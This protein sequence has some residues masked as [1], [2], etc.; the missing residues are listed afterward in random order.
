MPCTEVEGQPYESTQVY[1]QPVQHPQAVPNTV[2]YSQANPDL[3]GPA[4]GRAIEPIKLTKFNGK[5][6][7]EEFIADYL[8]IVHYNGWSD[9]QSLLQL[10]LALTG[11]AAVCK[12]SHSVELI[13]NDLRERYG[14]TIASS[15]RKYAALQ[16]GQLTLR[17]LGDEV[18]RLFHL[19][20]KT[21]SLGEAER[22]KI[23]KF[24][25]ALNNPEIHRFVLLS[26]PTSLVEAVRCAQAYTHLRR[27]EAR[28]V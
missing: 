21:S 23:V 25:S 10:R 5:S 19:S 22:Q 2:Y 3:L 6:D 16:Q 28:K 20:Q 14:E 17:Q 15:Q 18:E 4:L 13:L 1:R 11:E 9:S 8:D 26:R 24:L 7:V 27:P 12:R